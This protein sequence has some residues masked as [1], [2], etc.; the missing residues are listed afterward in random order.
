MSTTIQCSTISDIVKTFKDISDKLTKGIDK[1][2][3]LGLKIFDPQNKDGQLSYKLSLLS[4]ETA[5]VT[6]TPSSNDESKWDIV[7]T[8]EKSKKSKKY[9]EVKD[10]DA[11]KIIGD[12]I[13]E[14]Y[15]VK[16]S[17]IKSSK[18]IK[19]TFRKVTAAKCDCVELVSVNANYDGSEA[20]NDINTIVSDDTFVAALPCDAE[21]S[22]EIVDEGSSFDVTPMDSIEKA[23]LTT[24]QVDEIVQKAE[25]LL[26]D[27]LYIN[28][29]ASGPLT[30]DIRN[31]CSNLE[32]SA[33]SI[34]SMMMDYSVEQLDYT[35]NPLTCIQ[36]VPN[37]I[38][39]SDPLE[40]LRSNA[41]RLISALQLY[42]CN[43][44]HDFQST[45]DSW[46]RDLS[47]ISEYDLKQLQ[48]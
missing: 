3:D 20:W 11:D 9:T 36:N 7:L 35:P 22:Y 37:T 21:C 48:K 17:D 38:G 39:T 6:F 43:I 29:N 40:E 13:E 8:D 19:A 28:S 18:R 31:L 1:L 25:Y 45:F 32:W 27:I 2:F 24:D 47:H 4:G 30:S 26:L 23:D 10:S 33:R 12:A 5:Q 42:Y 14:M 46:I 34:T 44:T 15:G 16:L 41:S